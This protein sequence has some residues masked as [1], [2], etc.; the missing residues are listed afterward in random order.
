MPATRQTPYR[1]LVPAAAKTSRTRDPKRTDAETRPLNP[2]GN[3][4]LYV[5]TAPTPKQK[6]G[7]VSTY[8]FTLGTSLGDGVTTAALHLTS[9]GTPIVAVF[10]QTKAFRHKGTP[11]SALQTVMSLVAKQH[12]CAFLEHQLHSFL[13]REVPDAIVPLVFPLA[14]QFAY[15]DRGKTV[16]PLKVTHYYA[17]ERQPQRAHV[18]QANE[19]RKDVERRIEAAIRSYYSKGDERTRD[20]DWKNNRNAIYS[21]GRYLFHDFDKSI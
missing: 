10:K 11:E 18:K 12:S 6:M 20:Q 19:T 21:D 2:V 16:V 9:K 17:I 5:W 7:R 1:A 8:G 13:F 15:L 3:N 14:N 4:T